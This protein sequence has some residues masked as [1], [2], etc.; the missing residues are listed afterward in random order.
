MLLAALTLTAAINVEI[1]LGRLM[2]ANRANTPTSPTP[3]ART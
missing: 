3:T 2:K 1:D